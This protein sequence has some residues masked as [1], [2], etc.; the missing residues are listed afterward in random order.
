MLLA[1]LAVLAL[2]MAVAQMRGIAPRRAFRAFALLWAGV[3]LVNLWVG[4]AR[5]GYGL[6]EELPIAALVFAVPA[7]AGWLLLG[8]R[9]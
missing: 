6:A 8:R 1:G 3:T 9:G 4:M 7:A 5:A 2:G